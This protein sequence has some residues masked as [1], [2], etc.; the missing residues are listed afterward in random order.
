MAKKAG[1]D[2]IILVGGYNL[3]SY[4][5]Q[6]EVEYAANP[7]EV[8]GF[9]DGWKNYIPG[10]FSGQMSIDMYWDSAANSANAA[11]QTL[12]NK[13]V[14]IIPEGF[15]L[16]NHAMSMYA[17]QGNWKPTANPGAALTVGSVVFQGNG[18][19]A[20]PLSSV[21]LHHATIT[22]TTTDTGFVDPTDGAVTQRCIG[23]LHVWTPA[24]SDTYAITIEHSTTLG[25][26]YA[27]LVTF[28][29]NGSAR[30]S[31]Y[32]AVASGTINKYRRVVLTRT[33]AAGDNF[34]CSV[35][36]WHAGM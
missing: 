2:A 21:A 10:E 23:I 35:L 25:S 19:D 3:S 17:T 24:A 8:T 11:L 16:G 27:T 18:V 1:K 9:G 32:I 12:S 5:S 36:F 29:A 26:G 7:V 13:C 15:V 4:A 30:T 34:G 28:T 6:Y 20:G 14:S 33:G 22:T 31:Q